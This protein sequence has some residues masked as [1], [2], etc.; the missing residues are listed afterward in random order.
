MSADPIIPFARQAA[1]DV[2]DV[3]PVVA[4][5]SRRAPPWLFAGV[6]V[7]G[8]VVL[9]VVL[10]GRRRAATAPAT[11]ER[12]SNGSTVLASLPPLYVGPEQLPAP[13]ATPAASPGQGAVAAP[14]PMALPAPP[15]MT[16]P[17][18]PPSLPMAPASPPFTPAPPPGFAPPPNPV[19]QAMPASASPSSNASAL[20]IDT[21]QGTG[22]ATA[23]QTA[24][25]PTTARASRLG[26][27]ASIVPQG[28]LIPAVLETALDSTRPGLARAI[29]SQ[30]VRGFDGSRVLIPRGT[31][32]FGEYQ[33]DLTDGQNRAL[34][35]WTRLVRPDGVAI[36]IAS[37]AAD[38]SGRTGIPGRVN[39][40]FLAR[41]GNAFLQ[42]VL[43]VGMNLA[44]RGI[45]QESGL[46]V[47]LPGSMSGSTGSASTQSQVRPTLRVNAGVR[48]T[49]FVA[50]DL[51]FPAVGGRR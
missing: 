43:N 14:P 49:V 2:T 38:V 26:S 32:L 7:L 48:V 41:F 31:R 8:A 5:S 23:D 34:V 27:R 29:V 22:R 45:S 28:T 17:Y 50:Q 30:D 20:V 42:S 36:A 19:P 10:D 6:I 33:A 13:T 18:R 9:F 1:N 3:R 24:A 11:S 37:P 16:A 44:S 51:E 39:S 12:S 46:V 25:A 35:Q 21:T 15:P 40:H 4:G 47:A